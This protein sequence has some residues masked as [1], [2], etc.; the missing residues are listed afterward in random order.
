MMDNLPFIIAAATL[1]AWAFAACG[2]WAKGN[3]HTHTNQSDGDSPPETAVE[4][5]RGHGYNFLVISDHNKVV[6]PAEIS[7]S[8][9]DSFILIPG[10]EITTFFGTRP[11]HVNSLGSTVA[12]QPE[13]GTTMPDTI[14]RN[15][16]AVLAA[17]GLPEVNHPNFGYAFD[18]RDMAQV[19]RFSL[20][21]IYNGHPYVNNF[22]DADHLPVEQMWDVLLSSGRTI[23]GMA[24]D[25]THSFKTCVPS[26]ANPG[27]GWVMVRVEK[28][29]PGDVLN[30]L[31]NGDFYSST[32]VEL[33]DYS[34]N[35]SEIRISIRQSPGVTYSTDFIGLHGKI[36]K[37]ID[38]PIATYEFTGSKS[39]AYVRAKVIASDGT[40]A[41]TQPVR[42]SDEG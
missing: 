5:Y 30:G 16:D 4:W 9:Q 22:G 27:R 38:G 10:E 36:L 39:E 14:Q 33:T 8:S 28:L 3:T 7:I 21:E 13:T 29:T 2:M 11:V 18:E 25:D 40:V 19:R 23:Y 41:W 20:L 32:G 35:S 12:I 37:Q 26:D 34:A 42:A 15:V 31:K 17:G 1:I 6:D 24:V